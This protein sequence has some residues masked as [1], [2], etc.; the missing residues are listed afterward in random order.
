MQ[1]SVLTRENFDV[2]IPTL[3]GFIHIFLYI[4]QHEQK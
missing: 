3:N 2:Y 4:Y 1:N